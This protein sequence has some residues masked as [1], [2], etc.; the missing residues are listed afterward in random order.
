LGRLKGIKGRLQFLIK[1]NQYPAAW[2]KL[3]PQNIL[4]QEYLSTLNEGPA[5]WGWR[6]AKNFWNYPPEHTGQ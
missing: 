6:W 5:G 4:T 3:D 2:A 1:N